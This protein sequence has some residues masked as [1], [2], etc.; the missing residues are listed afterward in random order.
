MNLYLY[1]PNSVA[2]MDEIQSRKSAHIVT[3]HL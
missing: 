3:E 1:F 2:D